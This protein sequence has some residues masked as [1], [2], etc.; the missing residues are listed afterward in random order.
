MGAPRL[1]LDDRFW[2]KVQKSEGCWTWT[3]AKTS[4]GYGKLT[5]WYGEVYRHVSA[6][7]VSYELAKGSV[8][9]GLCIDHLCCNTSCVNPDHL[10]AVTSGENTR[11]Y[12][13]TITHCAQGHPFDE[14]NTTWAYAVKDGYESWQRV[15]KTCRRERRAEYRKQNPDKISAYKKRPEVR[16]RENARRRKSNRPS[17]YVPQ[18]TKPGE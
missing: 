3:G 2:K 9:E 4:R 7:K 12:T 6:H 11:R 15:C 17:E 16:E 13:N 14:E 18:C 8:P 5:M 10:E 1:S